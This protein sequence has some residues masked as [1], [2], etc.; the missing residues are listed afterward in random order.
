MSLSK[1]RPI[2]IES[3]SLFSY[4]IVYGVFIIFSRSPRS[5]RALYRVGTTRP[6][7]TAD[8]LRGSTILRRSRNCNRRDSIEK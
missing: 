8:A 5:S 1:S 2:V 4:T 6:T 3:A 7:I